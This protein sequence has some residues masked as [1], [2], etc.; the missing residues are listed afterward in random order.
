MTYACF[1]CLPPYAA[2]CAFS[3]RQTFVNFQKAVRPLPQS[4]TPLG[5][6]VINNVT[7]L[8]WAYNVA[9]TRSMELDGE[10]I[11]APLADM[12]NHAAQTN[13]EISYDRDGNCV[14]YA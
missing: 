2:Y 9:L 6:D 5:D 14:A 3:E 1:D 12:F 7:V 8:K 4:A 13:A 11:V 10:R